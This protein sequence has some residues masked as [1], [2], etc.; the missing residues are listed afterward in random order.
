MGKKRLAAYSEKAPIAILITIMVV[1][2]KGRHIPDFRALLL[3]WP[4]FMSYVISFI[5]IGIS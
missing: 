2:L 5:Y 4:V 1:E 3:L